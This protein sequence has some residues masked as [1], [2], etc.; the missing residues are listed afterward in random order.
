MLMRA[1]TVAFLLSA[2]ASTAM[3]D[4][5]Q[6]INDRSTFIQLLKDKSLTRLG[7]SLDVAPSGEIRGRAF[8]RDVTGAW[9]WNGGYFCRDLY[10]G[11][12]DLGPNC[13]QVRVKGRTMRFISDRGTGQ[14]ADLK[15]AQR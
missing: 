5:F 8:G 10:Y 13:Q 15:L 2:T 3:A 7:I 11:E 6:V 1:L 12:R 9:Q 14:F 4:G